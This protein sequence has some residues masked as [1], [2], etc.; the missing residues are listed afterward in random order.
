MP[1]RAP[2]SPRGDQRWSSFL[3]NHARAI[4]A[5]DFFVAVTATFQLLYM[6]VVIEHGSR[7]LLHCNVTGHPTAQWARQQ[8]RESLA[9]DHDYRYL[10]HDRDS[11]FS[12]EFDDSVRSLGLRVLKTPYRSP[13]ANAVCERLIGSIRREC[14]DFVIPLGERHLRRLLRSWSTYYN[15]SR[16]HMGLGAGISD[17]PDDVPVERQKIRHHIPADLRLESRPM[18]GGLHHDYRFAAA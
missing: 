12:V 7:R 10:I 17:P 16:P 1:R 2:G 5:C 6:L 8:L 15:R 18:L 9:S 4:V 3:R 13:K 11:I 14:L